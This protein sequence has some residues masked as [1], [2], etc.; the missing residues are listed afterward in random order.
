MNLK[1]NQ[2]DPASEPNAADFDE[3]LLN[4]ALRSGPTPQDLEA[5][6]LSLTDPRLLSLLDEALAPEAAPKQLADRIIAATMP[7]AIAQN[8]TTHTADAQPTV[9][10]RIGFS[11]WRYAA[12]AVFAAAA[13]AGIWWLTQQGGKPENGTD[14]PLVEQSAPSTTP[15]WTGSEFA[16]VSETYFA[17][18]TLPVETALQNVSEDFDRFTSDSGAIWSDFDNYEQFLS[19]IETTQ[20][21][22]AT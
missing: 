21:N 17:E 20:N 13:T 3:A 19:E 9:I 22:P 11:T 10:G 2:P 12:A 7:G 16:E 4:E 5:K 1:P 18:A 14:Q 15:E 6:V 8:T